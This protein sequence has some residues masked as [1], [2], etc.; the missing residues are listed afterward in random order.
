M[1]S[2]RTRCGCVAAGLLI[3]LGG[4]HAHA[5]AAPGEQ[6]E[7]E[8]Q[9]EA[10]PGSEGASS[11]EGSQSSEGEGEGEGEGSPDEKG[12]PGVLGGA[13]VHHA[14]VSTALAGQDIE[15]AA[16][17][18]N[19]HL[20]REARLVYRGSSGKAAAA[21]FRRG[22]SGKY[23]AVI[24]AAQVA[25]P[26]I[27]YAIEIEGVDG[28]RSDAFAAPATLHPVQVTKDRADVREEKLERK[29]EG[30]RSVVSSSGEYV[31][32]GRTTEEP[33]CGAATTCD[34]VVVDDQY[35]RVE[36]K[37]TYRPLRTIAEFSIR[38]GVVRGTSVGA[39]R[40]QQEVGLN[41]GA[42]SVRFRMADSWHLEAEGL[43]S[44]T[45]V[46]FSLGCG[47]SLLIGDPYG[48]KFV[49][50]FEVIGFSRDKYFGSRFFS[51]VDIAAH[52]RVV[53]APII[54]ISDF[55]HADR[56]GVRLL[57]DATA[58]IGGGFSAG[59]HGGYQARDAASG[60]PTLGGRL[61][62]AF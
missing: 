37:Y 49:G 21:P 1:V 13:R 11:E 8:T 50:G 26:L 34:P 22:D 54:E 61:A 59:V 56:F 15:I 24:P 60:G 7:A 27:G 52:E 29:V 23:V 2:Q 45:E 53:V 17:I 31:S 3:L 12:D 47:S 16:V 43:A 41:Y 28:Q 20:V 14:P 32:F 33:D 58:A 30:R 5:Q 62:L 44:I 19:P 48:S 25:P 18:D 36:G 39:D 4:E 35:W 6:V 51:R 40:R 9:P 57:A 55:P 46:G 42:P 38:G 10:T